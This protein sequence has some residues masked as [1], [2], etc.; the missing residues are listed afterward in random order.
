MINCEFK[1]G[2]LCTIS[3]FG[4]YPSDGVCKHCLNIEAFKHPHDFIVNSESPGDCKG[5]CKKENKHVSK[6]KKCPLNNWERPDY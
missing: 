4:P 3:V 2:R 5:I 1:E 6:M